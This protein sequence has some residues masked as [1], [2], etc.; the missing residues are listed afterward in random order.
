MGFKPGSGEQDELNVDS[1][2]LYVDN[3]NNRVGVNTESPATSLH[4]AG[5]AAFS[6][7]SK[8]FVT[9]GESDTTPSVADGNLFKTHASSQTLTMFDDGVTGQTITVISTAAVVFD[10]TSTN[11]KGGSTNITTAAGDIT[12]WTF[13]GT[14]WYLQQFMDVSADHSSVG[15]GGGGMSNWILEDGDGTEVTVG[16]GKEVKFV[17]GT[18]IDIDFT[19]TSDGSDADPYDLTFTVDLEGTELKSTGEGGGSKFLREDGDGSCSWQTISI[20]VTALNNATANEL[21]TV[22]ATTTELDAETNLTFNAVTSV[23]AVAGQVTAS[24]GITGSVVYAQQVSGAYL[25]AGYLNIN[26][27]TLIPTDAGT[28]NVVFGRSGSL[29]TGNAYNIVVGENAGNALSTGDNN[30]IIGHQAGDKTTDLDNSVIIG[31]QAGRAIMTLDADG[32]VLIGKAAGAAITSGVYNVAVGHQALTAEATGDLSTAVGHNALLSQT[33]VNG[34]VG[35]TAVGAAAGDALTTGIKNVFMGVNSG[36]ATTGVN[37]TVVVGYGAGVSNMT[38][39][40]DGTVIIGH[41]ACASLTTGAGNVAVGF[42]ALNSNV[43]GDFNTAVGYQA[44]E[45]FEADSDGHGNNT[46]VGYN[47]GQAVST[48]TGNTIVGAAAG[49][50]LQGGDNN[51]LI[52]DGAGGATTAAG[53]LV[54]IGAGAGAAVMTTDANGTIA[55]GKDAGAAITSGIGNTIVGYNALD[56]E[57]DGDQNTAVG[58]KALAAQNASAGEVGNTAV[59]YQAGQFITTATGCTFVGNQAGQGLPSPKLTGN[60]NTAVGNDA[61]LL[62][63]GAAQGNVFVGSTAGDLITSGSGNVCI[64]NAADPSTDGAQNQ[65]V[66]GGNTTGTANNEVALGNGSITTIAGAVSFGTYSDARIKKNVVDTDLGLAFI[67]S[68]RPVKFQR[69]NPADYP[70]EIL[71]PRFKRENPEE[72]PDDFDETSFHDG[73]IAQE[74]KSAMEEHG[75]SC[76][77]WDE[78]QSDGRQRIKYAVLVTPLIKAVQELTERVKELEDK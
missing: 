49:D 9:F 36:G 61:G 44:L 57:D 4:V 77:A 41:G 3:T 31:H 58:Y 62:L 60:N 19:D 35:N 7:P 15:G 47:A 16:D 52:G 51:T 24:M 17:E 75:V 10:V 22:G 71:E 56:S 64:G 34:T 28:S 12:T 11:L 13:D 18:G 46:A 66:I 42:E 29:G 32:T 25:E 48:G 78:A 70:S 69:V 37:Q 20:P 43:D 53:E 67:N 76:S 5:A 8:T 33:G 6:G 27:K 2:T 39:A 55:I 26:N 40:A 50:A 73:L 63:Q 72:R 14:N 21:V 1:G 59:G 65:I 38:A 54:I 68:L 74:L 23:L 30:V 45:T